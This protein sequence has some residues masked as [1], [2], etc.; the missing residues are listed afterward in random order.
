MGARRKGNRGLDACQGARNAAKTAADSD[1][2]A[3]LA[4]YDDPYIVADARW[5]F[6]RTRR[7]WFQVDRFGA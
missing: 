4:R 6:G 3:V 1:L 2:Y 7:A 5:A